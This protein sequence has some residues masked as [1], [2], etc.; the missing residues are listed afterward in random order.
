MKVY[1]Y[2]KLP[3]APETC[4]VKTTV[5]QLQTTE[6]N[7]RHCDIKLFEMQPDGYSPLHKH[8]SEHKVLVI[9]GEGVVFDGEKDYSIQSG[10]VIFIASNEQHQFKNTKEGPLRFLALTVIAKE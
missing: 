10:E 6:G 4:C 9:E 2:T 3:E 7:S 5:R 8:S 1:K